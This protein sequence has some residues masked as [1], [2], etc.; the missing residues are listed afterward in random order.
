MWNNKVSDGSKSPI[1]HTAWFE[2]S[3]TVRLV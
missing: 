2:V 3:Q 1:K